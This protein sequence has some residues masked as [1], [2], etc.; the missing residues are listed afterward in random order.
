MPEVFYVWSFSLRRVISSSPATSDGTSSLPRACVPG[1]GCSSREGIKPPQ[2]EKPGCR[3]NYQKRHWVLPILVLKRSEVFILVFP[4]P[5]FFNSNWN[6]THFIQKTEKEPRTPSSWLETWL[7]PVFS[8]EI[9][10]IPECRRTYQH[11]S[12]PNSAL[13]FYY[14]RSITELS[15]GHNVFKL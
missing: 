3:R 9:A 1:R 13:R 10:Q 8:V 5:F 15:F 11:R 14:S 7:F 4:P 2:L 6:G 12:C